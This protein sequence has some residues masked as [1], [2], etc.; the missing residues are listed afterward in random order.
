VT[1]TVSSGDV[2]RAKE[3]GAKVVIDFTRARFADLVQGVDAVLDTLG[4]A[5]QEASWATLKP[6]GVMVA[7]SQP[8]S[9]ERAL[10]L[11][12]RAAMVDAGRLQAVPCHSYPLAEA[13]QVHVRGEAGNLSGRTVLLALRN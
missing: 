11:G 13:Q 7:L 12:V 8:P 10:A 9:Q 6:G 5:T 2:A 1:T 3:L 4:G